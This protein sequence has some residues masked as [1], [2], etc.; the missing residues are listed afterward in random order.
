MITYAWHTHVRLI[1]CILVSLNISVSI[2]NFNFNVLLYYQYSYRS[3]YEIHSSFHSKFTVR[4][5]LIC[6]S[7]YTWSAIFGVK[8]RLPFSRMT[9]SPGWPILLRG[10]VIEIQNLIVSSG[11]FKGVYYSQ[12]HENYSLGPICCR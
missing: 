8:A 1:F 11:Y 2:S 10:R 4:G 12:F 5:M 7:P 6:N 9:Q 3:S